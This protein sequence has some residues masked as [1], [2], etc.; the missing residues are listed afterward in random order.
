M[1]EYERAWF[2][3]VAMD[4]LKLRG[5]WMS[6][7]EIHPNGNIEGALNRLWLAGLVAR[8]SAC[9]AWF[10]PTFPE[11]ASKRVKVWWHLKV[12]K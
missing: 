4:G 9:S 6:N 5:G 10:D 11:G 8:V 7:S 2:E 12:A 3:N 1:D